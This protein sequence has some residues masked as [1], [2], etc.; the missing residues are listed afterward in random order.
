MNSSVVSPP[1]SLSGRGTL[2]ILVALLVLGATLRIQGLGAKSLWMDELMAIE[3]CYEATTIRGI[4]YLAARQSQP[5]LDYFI[6]FALAKVY[7]FGSWGEFL[8]RFPAAGFSI[9]ALGMLFVVARTAGD[10]RAALCAVLLAAV[11]PGLVA[12]AQEARPYSIFFFFYLLALGAFYRCVRHGHP[13]DWIAFGGA[14]FL[15]LL[16]KGMAPVAVVAAL[17]V[18]ILLSARALGAAAGSPSRFVV[19]SACALGVATALFLPFL[20]VTFLVSQRYVDVNM[21]SGAVFANAMSIMPLIR[22]VDSIVPLVLGRAGLILVPFYIAAGVWAWRERRDRPWT[23]CLFLVSVAEPVIHTFMY[24]A[25]VSGVELKGRYFLH[26]KYLVLVFGC[27]GIVRSAQLL[28]GRVRAAGWLVVPLVILPMTLEYGAGVRCHYAEPR[29]D[30]RAVGEYFKR[31]VR[32]MDDVL[33]FFFV[34]YDDKKWLPFIHGERVYFPHRR[35]WYLHVYM[36][37]VRHFPDAPNNLHFLLY[38]Y[39]WYDDQKPDLGLD[40][41]RFHV[42]IY[43]EFVIIRVRDPHLT[44]REAVVAMLDEME[45]FYPQT[46]ARARLYRNR[47]NLLCDDD[48]AAAQEYLAMAREWVPEMQ[49]DEDCAG[50]SPHDSPTQSRITTDGAD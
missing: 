24:H 16:S 39:Q 33:L 45:R 27:I 2:W 12:Y 3:A 40:P 36:R 22:L 21:D 44:R 25:V 7:D 4:T 42:E 19:K 28:C 47:A 29:P 6:S 49:L 48:P 31:D 20:R 14:S 43:H 35:Q 46:S 5:P 15:M 37:E 13:V 10:V 41:K 11:S 32:R 30:Y 9:A 17:S 26:S 18:S 1:N 23:W 50:M 8:F 34:P 38:T